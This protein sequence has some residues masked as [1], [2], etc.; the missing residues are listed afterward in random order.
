M[1]LSI[2]V[3]KKAARSNDSGDACVE[4]GATVEIVAIRDSKN[5]DGPKLILGRRE[6]RQLASVIKNL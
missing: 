2:K 5:P 1:D 3:W 4:V 6:F